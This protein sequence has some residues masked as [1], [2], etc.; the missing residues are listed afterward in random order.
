MGRLFSYLFLL[1]FVVEIS[2]DQAF[3]TI[4]HDEMSFKK[5]EWVMLVSY[6]VCLGIGH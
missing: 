4:P 1:L 2:S 3:P 6:Q 5:Y